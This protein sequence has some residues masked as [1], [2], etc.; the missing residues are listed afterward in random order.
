MDA[1]NLVAE[2]EAIGEPFRLVLGNWTRVRCEA[3]PLLE[4]HDGDRPG[5]KRGAE[6]SRRAHPRCGAAP[7]AGE[8]RPEG[9]VTGGDGGRSSR[10]VARRAGPPPPLPRRPDSGARR[11]KTAACSGRSCA[12]PRRRGSGSW[13]SGKPSSA[14]IVSTDSSGAFSSSVCTSARNSSAF[15]LR[16]GNGGLRNR[17]TGALPGGIH[18]SAQRYT[19]AFSTCTLSADAELG[20]RT[21]GCRPPAAG[22]SRSAGRRSPRG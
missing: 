18:R 10:R 11:H 7:G 17:F 14:W 21:S 22:P 6:D 15:S 13:S 2:V 8:K 20:R 1:R 9:D 5:G 16:S 3:P 19:S 12:R 4:H